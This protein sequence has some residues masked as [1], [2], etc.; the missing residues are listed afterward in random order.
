MPPNYG[1]GEGARI[2]VQSIMALAELRHENIYSGDY[3]VAIYIEEVT[4]E[5]K[6]KPRAQNLIL[7]HPNLIFF[8]YSA[9]DIFDL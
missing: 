9:A 6:A 4:A 7:S 1:E 2:V 5:K 3:G 8:P